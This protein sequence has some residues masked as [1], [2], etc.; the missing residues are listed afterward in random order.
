MARRDLRLESNVPGSFYVDSTCIDCA[1]CRVVAPATFDRAGEQSR[2]RSQPRDAAEAERA[3]AALLSCPTASIGTESRQD[4]AAASKRFPEPVDSEVSYCGFSSEASFGAASY[5]IARPG[6]NVLVDSPRFA[7][8]LVENLERLGGVRWLFLT[9]RDDVADHA[10]FRARF[11]CERV[12]HEADLT[13]DTAGVEVVVR[14]EGASE[15]APDLKVIP[16][17]GH[18][19]GSACLLYRDR[20][21]FSGDHLAQNPRDG[22]LYAFRSACWYDW[23]RQIESMERLLRFRFEFVLP[24]HGHRAR[25]DAEQMQRELA[26]CVAWMRSHPADDW[27]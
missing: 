22:S 13:P 10:K 14:G 12:L 7:A 25:F 18:T 15:L 4:L 9:H 23:D 17:P 19:E 27:A 1:T 20:Y 11:G 2:V 3:L 8:P 21:L 16:V 6:G 26:A 24:G 5:F